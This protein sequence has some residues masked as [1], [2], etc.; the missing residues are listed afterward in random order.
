MVEA[1][2]RG[3]R[4]AHTHELLDAGFRAIKIPAKTLRTLVKF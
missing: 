3:R 1:R 2:Y 4:T